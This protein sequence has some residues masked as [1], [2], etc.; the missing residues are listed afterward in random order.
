MLYTIPI[1]IVS[2][3]VL[4][5]RESF[6]LSSTLNA[7]ITAICVIVY[8]SCFVMGL[9]AIPNILC[10]EIFP[11]NVRGICISI[12]SLTFWI[13]ILIVTSSFPFL[14]HLFGLTGVFG[15]YVCG[16]ILS[17]IFVYMKVPETKGMPLEVIIEFF[18]IGAKPQ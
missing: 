9:G 14:L 11:T 3:M 10:S 13:S 18:A 7:T 5:F 16:C 6:H 12:C 17:W 15:L 2:L 4:V 8:E 1:L